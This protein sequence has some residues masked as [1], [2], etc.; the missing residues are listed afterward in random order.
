MNMWGVGNGPARP[1][2]MSDLDIDENLDNIIFMDNR[3]RDE[4]QE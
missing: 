3:M 1:R 4:D 2:M